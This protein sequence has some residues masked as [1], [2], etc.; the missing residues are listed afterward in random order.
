MGEIKC[1]TCKLADDRNNNFC[2]TYYQNGEAMNYMPTEDDQTAKADDGKLKLT[3]VPTGIIRAIAKIRMFG[4]A[5][6]KN[7]DNWKRV[8]KQRY[9]D[10]ACRHFLEYLDNPSA[11]DN[12]SGLPALYHLACNIA[13]LIEMENKDGTFKS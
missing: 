4:V 1:Y 12:E 2:Q 7:P 10:A 13:F 5:K 3:Y 9:K 8:E 6:Y 11:V